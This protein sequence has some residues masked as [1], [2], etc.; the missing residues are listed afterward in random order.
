ICVFIL[1]LSAGWYGTLI[2]ALGAMWKKYYGT[3]VSNMIYF[4]KNLGSV[5][6]SSTVVFLYDWNIKLPFISS[7]LFSIGFLLVVMIGFR[8]LKYENI[9]CNTHKH[10][11]VKVVLPK[12]N[13]YLIYSLFA[14]LLVTWTMYQQW[15]SNVSVYIT[16]L[17]I[18]FRYY[19]VLWTINA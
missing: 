15:G 7:V 5:I 9:Y 11:I 2:S 6:A 8:A 10:S 16:S 14:M 1:E 17:G 18:P 4:I 12:I 13:M 3:Y 19:S